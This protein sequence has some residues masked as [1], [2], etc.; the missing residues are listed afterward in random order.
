MIR[1]EITGEPVRKQKQLLN[2][3]EEKLLCE[4]RTPEG[5][6]ICYYKMW[7]SCSLSCSQVKYSLKGEE[8]LL[9]PDHSR[10]EI[11]KDKSQKEY[12]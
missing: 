11:Q 3:K 12:L 8:A 10:K 4:V 7:F 2:H 6:T 1:C 9:Y 5:N